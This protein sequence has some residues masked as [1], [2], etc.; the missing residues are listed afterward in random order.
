MLSN[1]HHVPLLDW[2]PLPVLLRAATQFLKHCLAPARL[3]RGTRTAYWLTPI[4]LSVP[5][6]T[7]AGRRVSLPRPSA[8]V[9]WVTGTGRMS[10]ERREGGRQS[11]YTQK[12]HRKRMASPAGHAEAGQSVLFVDSFDDRLLKGTSATPEGNLCC[13][14]DH[15]SCSISCWAASWDAKVMVTE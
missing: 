11:G 1:Y 15:Q 8:D 7:L 12:G 3:H 14:C 6:H 5:G 13:Q 4:R 10:A 9:G 2:E